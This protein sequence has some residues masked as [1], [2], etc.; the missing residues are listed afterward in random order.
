MNSLKLWFFNKFIGFLPPTRF[1]SLK[2]SL[3]SWA[4]AEVSRTVRLVSSVKIVG[5]GELKIGDDTFIGHEVFISCSPPGIEIGSCVDLAPR[6]TVVNG[7]HEIDMEGR[8]SA[9]KGKC[10]SIKI[11][12][13]VWIGAGATILSGV[14]IGEKAVI[15]AGSL[16]NGDIPSFTVAGG[17]PCK[18]IKK[19]D[20]K[21]QSWSPPAGLKEC[22]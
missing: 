5:P 17:V 8:H 19:W 20:A 15:A 10:L 11:E 4:G 21:T 16:V 12:D 2:R 7:T 3:L 1:Y 9:G 13:G 18:I 22:T 14:T 6:V